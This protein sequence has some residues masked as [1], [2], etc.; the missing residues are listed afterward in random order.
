MKKI[1]RFSLLAVM[2]MSVAVSCK[3]NKKSDTSEVEQ[4]QGVIE[5]ISPGNLAQ[6]DLNS[7]QLIDVRKQE[8]MAKGAIP[9]AQNMDYFADDFES[10]V[11]ELDKSEPIYVYCKIGGRSA[12]AAVK[13]QEMGFERIYD[14]DGGIMAWIDQG[15]NIE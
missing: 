11:Q 9:G 1:L 13:L 10:Q 7:L 12:R 3:E 2:F 5:F 15:N 6:L 8:E 4:V 14:L